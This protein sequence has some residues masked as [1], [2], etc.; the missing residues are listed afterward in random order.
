MESPLPHVKQSFNWDCGLACV[1][2]VLRAVGDE[3]SAD[4]LRA[5]AATASVWTIDLA[6][7]LEKH[8]LSVRYF[9]SQL[10][11]NP[12]FEQESFYYERLRDDRERVERLFRQAL[13]AG[14]PQI[15]EAVVSREALARALSEGH[16]LAIILIDRSYLYPDEYVPPRLDRADGDG[17]SEDPLASGAVGGV[18][19]A[20]SRF[21]ADTL[22]AI[23]P[24]LRASEE[25]LAPGME[26]AQPLEPRCGLPISQAPL[27]PSPAP[28]TPVKDGAGTYIGHYVIALGISADGDAFLVSDPAAEPG[29]ALVPFDRFD[30][31]RRSFGTDDDVL[32]IRDS[33]LPSA[34]P[35]AAAPRAALDNVP[36]KLAVAGPCAPRSCYRERDNA[37]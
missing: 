5:Q 26:I 4:E 27:S 31:A 1:E 2:T 10:G 17:H 37:R 3:T 7:L 25:A 22:G 15:E 9:T 16:T 24:S 19:A 18:A 8:G 20:L 35:P 23:I 36:S 21:V 28:P 14:R 33:R 12:A 13:S 11:V 6:F 29:L 32:I 30:R 34:A